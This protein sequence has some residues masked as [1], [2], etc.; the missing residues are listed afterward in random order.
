MRFEI[1]AIVSLLGLA[2]AAPNKLPLMSRGNALCSYCTSM[3]QSFCDPA[4]NEI[5]LCYST[6][7]DCNIQDLNQKCR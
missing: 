1:L 6:G 4:T 2:A 3:Y 5:Y 7:P